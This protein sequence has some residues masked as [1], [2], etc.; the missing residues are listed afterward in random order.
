[1]FT[2]WAI[3]WD[4]KYFGIRKNPFF[5]TFLKALLYTILIIV[6]N[7]FLFQP[8]IEHFF[9]A[10]DLSSLEGL[11]G[12]I[13]SYIIFILFMWVFAAFGEEFFYRG[14]ITKR[15]AVIFGN[16]QKAWM[17]SILIS[18]IIFGFAHLYQGASGVIT[19]GFVAIIFGV[20]FYKNQHNL[21]V[22]IL[23]HGIYD[24]FGITMIFFDKE[25]LITNWVQENIFFF[26]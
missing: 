4:W 3:K 25:R 7:D 6:V 18:S 17:I 16:S 5:K 1:L 22:G 26:I 24:V 23:A 20:I 8:V 9:G 10:T 11:K 12:N 21:W 2:V 19:T 14:Y 13:T 15:I